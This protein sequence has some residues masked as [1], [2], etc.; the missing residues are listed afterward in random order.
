MCELASV[1][2]CWGCSHHPDYFVS[3]NFPTAIKN[4]L[5]RK[6]QNSIQSDPYDLGIRH[7]S[8]HLYARWC[9]IVPCKTGTMRHSCLIA[10]R[11]LTAWIA[12]AN[13]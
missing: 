9:G 8:A 13:G 7:P 11:Y 6:R 5:Q 10:K 12:L 1:S 2:M 3:D 4:W